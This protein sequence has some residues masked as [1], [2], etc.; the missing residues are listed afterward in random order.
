MD[1]SRQ[2]KERHR[3]VILFSGGGS[4]LEHLIHAVKQEYIPNSRVCL[5]LSN[6]PDAGGLKRAENAGVPFAVV[7]HKNFS[8]RKLFE[9]ILREVIDP[10]Q[11]DLVVLAG[12]MRVLGAA[13][14]HHYWGRLINIHPSL[15]PKYPG[16]K[17]HQRVIEA[18]DREHGCTV[19]FVTA[20]L[21]DG[22]H[23]I[24]GRIPVL[25]DEQPAELAA[26]LLPVEHRVLAQAVKWLIEDRLKL[27]KET[28]R[29]MLDEQYLPR[30]GYQYEAQMQ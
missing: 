14:V 1:E 7:D 25:P 26:R 11:P 18:G 20:I 13:F 4:T 29:V 16:L 22:P 12:F 30:A 10:H 27:E 19:H 23:I 21:D 15:L 9:R 6:R 5:A 17:T 24:Q 8:R 2:A 3:L 28:G